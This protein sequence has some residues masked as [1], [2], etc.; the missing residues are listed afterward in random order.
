MKVRKSSGT[1][2][3]KLEKLQPSLAVPTFG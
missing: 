2:H 1:A 3:Q